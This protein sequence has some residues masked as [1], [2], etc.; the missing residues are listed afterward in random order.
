[1]L[2]RG[3]STKELVDFNFNHALENNYNLLILGNS[4]IYRGINPDKLS[5]SA[6]N[7]AFDAE[8]S[9]QYWCVY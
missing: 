3:P 4:R 9:N 5:L 6:Y 1:M 7:F 2:V 8:Y